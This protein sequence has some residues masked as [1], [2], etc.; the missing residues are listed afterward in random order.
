MKL[1]KLYQAFRIAYAGTGRPVWIACRIMPNGKVKPRHASLHCPIS[2]P[3][4]RIL[5]AVDACSAPVLNLQYTPAVFQIALHVVN[6]QNLFQQSCRLYRQAVFLLQLKE[7]GY[8]E[9]H[10]E[11]FAAGASSYTC[12]RA[13]LF[14]S[15]EASRV[16]ISFAI[17]SRRPLSCLTDSYH[18]PSST[19][20]GS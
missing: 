20:L 7:H 18:P 9:S 3:P 1:P 15:I 5:S 2:T 19:S 17:A 6:N 8:G 11:L 4:I 16:P 14:L 13:Q 12:S 10:A